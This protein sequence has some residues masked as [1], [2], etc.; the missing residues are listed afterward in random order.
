PRWRKIA[1]A[2][3]GFKVHAQK[4]NLTSDSVEAC[5]QQETS[6]SPKVQ[7]SAQP[8]SLT[9]HLIGDHPLIRKHGRGQIQHLVSYGKEGEP[10]QP[11]KSSLYSVV[12]TGLDEGQ[13]YCVAVVFT[14]FS[15]P[16][17]PPS[18]AKCIDIP[19]SDERANI[20]LGLGLGLGFLLLLVV[21]VVLTMVYVFQCEK[22]KAWMRPPYTMPQCIM[23]P[24]DAQPQLTLVYN[25][26][27]ISPVEALHLRTATLPLHSSS[28]LMEHFGRGSNIC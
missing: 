4:H 2:V 6:C 19:Q 14:Y 25:E 22:I 11:S 16:I 12:I 28:S 15:T 10:L 5:S 13:R 21:L 27:H 20:T 9:V 23:E 24:F 26:E 1:S 3:S 8:G 7:L 18:C 17:A